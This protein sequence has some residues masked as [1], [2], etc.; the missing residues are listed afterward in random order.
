MKTTWLKLRLAVGLSGAA[1]L[2]SC[3]KSSETTGGSGAATTPGVTANDR[4]ASLTAQEIAAKSRDAYAALSSYSDTGTVISEMAGKTNALSFKTRLQRPNLYRI[5]WTQTEVADVPL[6]AN[7]GRVWSDG[8]GDYFAYLDV[9]Q[10]SVRP[11][12]MESMKQA[13]SQAAGP[14]WSAASMISGVFFNQEGVSD[15]FLASL[16]SG[17]LP[18][19]REKDGLAGGVDCYVLSSVMGSSP[20]PEKSQSSSV[21]TLWIG[22]LDF[23]IHQSRKRH[24]ARMD[25]S[26]PPSE[27]EIDEAIRKSLE[28]QRQVV[29]AEA[30]AA[31]R[32]QMKEIMQQVRSTLKAGFESGI[33][34]TRTHEN[35]VV[36]TTYSPVDFTR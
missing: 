13:L 6:G 30:I 18:L 34:F 7:Q 32:P 19:Q 35:I 20:Q 5:D 22:K 1:L 15:V 9:G 4:E 24:M 28:L 31:M 21:T 3:G 8:N 12:K 23:L 2:V 26:A 27:P 11:Q 10:K 29:T 36:N 14:S 17:R 33:V 16:A 25:S